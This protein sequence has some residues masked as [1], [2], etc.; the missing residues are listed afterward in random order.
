MMIQGTHLSFQ[1]RGLC[2]KRNRLGLLLAFSVEQLPHVDRGNDRWIIDI[3]IR[4]P[5][6]KAPVLV[7]VPCK[8]KI[9][10]PLMEQ[11]MFSTGPDSIV[12]TIGPPLNKLRIRNQTRSYL[13]EDTNDLRKTKSIP[14]R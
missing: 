5:N 7:I 12:Y 2:V 10:N 11:D 9:N 14:G 4:S 6:L 1:E 13:R 8:V 3:Q